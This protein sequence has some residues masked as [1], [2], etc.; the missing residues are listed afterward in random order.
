MTGG[1]GKFSRFPAGLN[2]NCVLSGGQFHAAA[3]M[4]F[5]FVAFLGA[6]FDLVAAEYI[7][8]IGL[9]D[10]FMIVNFSRRRPYPA[11][12]FHTRADFP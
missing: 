5:H 4:D 6:A 12:N 2:L 10:L 7:Q 1:A 11:V 9:V 8:F 3:A